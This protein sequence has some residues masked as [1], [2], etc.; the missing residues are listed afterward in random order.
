MNILVTLAA[1]AERIVGQSNEHAPSTRQVTHCCYVWFVCYYEKEIY[2]NHMFNV[3]L[4]C[5]WLAI[6]LRGNPLL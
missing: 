4:L 5:S 1:F 3:G 6:T 2:F